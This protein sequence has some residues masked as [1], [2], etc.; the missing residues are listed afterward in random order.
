[1]LEAAC[2]EGFAVAHGPALAARL[3]GAAEILELA[4][5]GA[6]E[7]PASVARGGSGAALEQAGDEHAELVENQHRDQLEER[8]H[9]V[10][11]G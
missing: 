9:N 6:Q 4:P 7:H 5:P 8:G 10:G 2:L 1:M 3:L 11:A